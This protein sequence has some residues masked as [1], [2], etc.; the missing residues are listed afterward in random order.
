VWGRGGECQR[1]V[2]GG[3]MRL[4]FCLYV[5]VYFC[6]IACD[7]C[8]HASKRVHVCEVACA[9]LC[10]FARMAFHVQCFLREMLSGF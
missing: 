5:G 10:E 4:R 7:V 3:C 1:G 2:G 6:K 9:S 8:M